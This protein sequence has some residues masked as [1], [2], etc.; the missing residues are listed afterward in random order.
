VNP[1]IEQIYTTD[2]VTD[3]AGNKIPT[4]SNIEKREGLFLAGIIQADPRIRKTLEI[5]FAQGLS[6]LFICSALAGREGAAHTILDPNQMTQWKGV[7]IENMRRAGFSFYTLIQEYSQF[8]L[9]RLAQLQPASFDF[10]F[11]DAGTPSIIP[12]S[13]FFTPICC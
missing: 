1:V 3:A 7:G 5:G 11:I 4:H 8:A 9:P 10:I 2:R 6:S 12:C 13:I